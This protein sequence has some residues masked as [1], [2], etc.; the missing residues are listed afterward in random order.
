MKRNVEH[1]S[2][3][4]SQLRCTIPPARRWKLQALEENCDGASNHFVRPCL[5]FKA[6]LMP[7]WTADMQRAKNAQPAVAPHNNTAYGTA[8]CY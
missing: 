5:D 8:R 4:R 2:L 6:C 7:F 3:G 1:R